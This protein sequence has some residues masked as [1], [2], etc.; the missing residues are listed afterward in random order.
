MK[1]RFGEI[2]SKRV[3]S[4]TVSFS[5]PDSNGIVVWTFKNTG[6]TTGS[7]L[8]QRGASL[9]GQQFEDYVFGQAFN[10]IYL[11]NGSLFGT[12]LLTAPPTPL[13]KRQYMPAM[14]SSTFPASNPCIIC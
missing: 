13:E 8:L 2:L 3:Q 14:I 4:A 1:N 6:N 7:W 11:Y 5:G 10:V 9:A 12:E